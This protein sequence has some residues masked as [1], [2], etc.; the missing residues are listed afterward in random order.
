MQLRPATLKPT[1][2]IIAL[3]G[4]VLENSYNYAPSDA[5]LNNDGQ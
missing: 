4:I 5:K 2:Y 1:H 3:L